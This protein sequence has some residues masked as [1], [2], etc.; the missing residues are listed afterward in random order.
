M[1]LLEAVL[2]GHIAN[3][4]TVNRWNYLFSGDAAA[5]GFSFALANAMGFVLSG[6]PPVPPSGTIFFAMAAALGTNWAADQVIIRDVYNPL[7]FVDLPFI[8]AFAGTNGD[9]TQGS[10]I[11]AYAVRSNRTRLDIKRGKKAFPGVMLGDDDGDGEIS[12]VQLARVQTIADRMG[13][14]LSFVDGANTAT[15]QPT[16][17]QREKYTT[18]S[19][20][21]AYRYYAS[22]A[23]QSPG[24]TM[25][26]I[27]W[28]A[29]STIRGQQSRQYNKGS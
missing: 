5:N 12:S 8:P 1:G 9:G 11:L 22:F 25:T 19:G 6:S 13:D 21:F 14:T 4:Q 27:T 18:P 10:P 20:K 15:F 16:V 24:H 2:T 26:G 23:T 28:E 3:Q 7:D 29:V 17:V